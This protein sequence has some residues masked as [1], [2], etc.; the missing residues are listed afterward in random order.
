[1][2]EDSSGQF[3]TVRICPECMGNALEVIDRNGEYKII[4]CRWCFD[5]VMDNKQYQV[6]LF[7]K[8]LEEHR[9]P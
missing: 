5:G 7:A 2:S 6:W 4:P 1:M 8:G 3:S 9:L